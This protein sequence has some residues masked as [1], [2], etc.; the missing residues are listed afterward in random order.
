MCDF[1]FFFFVHQS[2]IRRRKKVKEDVRLA[3]LVV[4][5]KSVYVC[6]CERERVARV[7][8]RE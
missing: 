7:R 5:V 4:D 8:E 3:R 6:P 1:P 2:N